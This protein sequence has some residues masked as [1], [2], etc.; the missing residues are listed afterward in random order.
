MPKINIYT[1]PQHDNFVWDLHRELVNL[2]EVDTLDELW[3]LDNCT[4]IINAQQQIICGPYARLQAVNRPALANIHQFL[5]KN[6]NNK[7]IMLDIFEAG[8]AHYD[9]IKLYNLIN[10]V[11][12]KRILF[13]AAGESAPDIEVS[14]QDICIGL[15]ANRDNVNCSLQNFENIYAKKSKPYTFILLNGKARHHRI[16]L[17]QRLGQN[18]V[19]DNALWS[20]HDIDFNASTITNE[21]HV[22][23]TTNYIRLNKLPDGYDNI[24]IV[25]PNTKGDLYSIETVF[26]PKELMQYNLVN[27]EKQYIDSYFSVI[28]EQW[29]QFDYPFV[30]EKTLRPIVMGHPFVVVSS[31]NF[32]KKLKSMGFKTFSSLIDESFDSIMN[33]SDRLKRAAESI[34]ALARL[35]KANLDSFL[36][37]SKEICEYNRNNL[38]ALHGTQYINNYNNMHNFIIRNLIDA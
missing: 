14:A 2:I 13:V 25:T 5:N 4:I 19:L 38:L 7:I 26:A 10:Y 16:A 32:Y 33:H 37:A 9:F 15:T 31:P 23:F 24:Q 30:T 12:E 22:D 17:L 3:Q 36:A 21:Y 29:H 18:D 11:T 1:T 28:A 34:T 8:Q 35:D 6:S 27:T 20:L